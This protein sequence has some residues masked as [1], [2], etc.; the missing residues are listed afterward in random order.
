MIDS[1][2]RDRRS[3]VRLT[4]PLAGPKRAAIFRICRTIE[5]ASAWTR[6]LWSGR[7]D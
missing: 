4:V 2:W 6:R 7:H 3:V 1:L 5:N